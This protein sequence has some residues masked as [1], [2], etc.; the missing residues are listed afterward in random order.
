MISC[1]FG[2]PKLN[3]NWRNK[4]S[5]YRGKASLNFNALIKIMGWL[6]MHDNVMTIVLI[7]YVLFY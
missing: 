5:F 1:Y 3:D 6:N 7:V 2:I 4:R